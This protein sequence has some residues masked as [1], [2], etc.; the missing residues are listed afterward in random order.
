[1]ALGEV[2]VAGDYA[3]VVNEASAP[4]YTPGAG[5]EVVVYD[6]RTGKAVPDRGGE[7]MGCPF[8]EPTYPCGIDQLVLGTDAV[9][10]A[11]AFVVTTCEPSSSCT[12]VESIVAS[13]STGRHVLDS[14]TTTG[15][16]NAAPVLSQLAL[17]GDTLTWSHAGSPRSAQLS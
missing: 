10:A 2:Q 3:A 6:L 16:V 15:S 13:D 8:N 7:S 4:H 1:V 14:I 12:L 17:S 11:H 9:S 5:D